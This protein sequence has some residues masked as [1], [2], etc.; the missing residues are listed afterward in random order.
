[1]KSNAEYQ[2]ITELEQRLQQ[3]N[4]I[5]IC[6]P[7]EAGTAFNLAEV[8]KIFALSTLLEESAQNA[9]GQA[10]RVRSI[11]SERV[12]QLHNDVVQYV[13]LR[14]LRDNPDSLQ[15][16]ITQYP[17]LGRL[18][19]PQNNAWFVY[20]YP[21]EGNINT[22]LAKLE[23][24][25]KAYPSALVSGSRW[26]G[27]LSTKAMQHDMAVALPL[28]VLAILC[29]FVFMERAGRWSLALTLAV[30]LPAIGTLALYPLHD[31]TL[32][33]LT[34]LA[35]I[36][37]LILSTT[38]VIHVFHHFSHPGANI[39]TLYQERGQVLLWSNGT[40][41][42]G[43]GSLL[44]SPLDDLRTNGVFIIIGLFIAAFWTLFILPLCLSSKGFKTKE[45]GNRANKSENIK[46]QPR[47]R[48]LYVLLILSCMPGL[49]FLQ[50]GST[51]IYDFFSPQ[52]AYTEKLKQFSS[53]LPISGEIHLYIDSGREYGLIEPDFYENIK[54][55]RA[56][57]EELETVSSVYAYSDLIQEAA[58]VL[59]IAANSP[60]SIGETMELLPLDKDM[61]LLYDFNWRLTL[62]RLVVNI[63]NNSSI[64]TERMIQKI[65]DSAYLYFPKET[66]QTGGSIV[67]SELGMRG[68]R[69]GQLY[70]LAGY[71]ICVFI[72]VF[73]RLRSLRK[74]L[75]VCVGPLLSIL[76]IL[77]LSAYLGWNL[78]PMLSLSL[79]SL[80][81]VGIDD[82]FIWAFFSHNPKLK[83][84]V[85][86]TTFTLCCGLA[87]LLFSYHTDLIR[88]TILII[89]GFILCTFFILEV[90]PWYKEG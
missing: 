50:S 5:I 6:L 8:Q 30:L 20:V 26:V 54:L 44:L 14:S 33:T 46:R 84:S 3:P 87:T 80:A 29:I 67:L 68:L 15:E 89:T 39:R 21:D 22:I 11:F 72:A 49:F 63:D 60:E 69:T 9:A 18:F 52:F 78:S 36:L 57:L 73:I 42:L 28:T 59:H 13:E 53:F 16:V 47:L 76:T 88:G 66:V 70:G 12:P 64:Q 58:R 79:A 75:Q 10:W 86:A 27:Y 40:S 85:I 62:L 41:I 55:L 65:K 31:I 90:L 71:F 51:N 48:I 38:Y 82:S 74:S 61:P 77:G 24:L 25:L 34:I 37:V 19:C 4:P 43:F 1:M 17:T 81:G 2:R 45:A 35:P 7:A 32:K 23:K 83:K 56:D